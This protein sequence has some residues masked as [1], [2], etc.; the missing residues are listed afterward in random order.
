MTPYLWKGMEAEGKK[1]DSSGRNQISKI[2]CKSL[3]TPWDL[4]TYVKNYKL[5]KDLSF[6]K[7]QYWEDICFLS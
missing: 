5:I 3:N 6:A 4:N 2:S 7:F 1:D